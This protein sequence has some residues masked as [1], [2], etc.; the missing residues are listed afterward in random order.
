MVHLYLIKISM[1]SCTFHI[2]PTKH[3][4]KPTPVVYFFCWVTKNWK[5]RQQNNAEDN[6]TVQCDLRREEIEERERNKK[7]TLHIISLPWSRRGRVLNWSCHIHSSKKVIFS[8]SQT[9]CLFVLHQSRIEY[10]VAALAL[11]SHGLVV[12]D[13]VASGVFNRRGCIEMT[14]SV[15]VKLRNNRHLNCLA[16]STRAASSLA[17]WWPWAYL[18]SHYHHLLPP[19]IRLRKDNN[20]NKKN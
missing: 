7:T 19:L 15:A 9:R 10:G 2:N 11:P 8:C 20:K 3:I 6:L 14:C 17:S 13:V 18:I 12:G 1:A 4:F 16:M 5:T